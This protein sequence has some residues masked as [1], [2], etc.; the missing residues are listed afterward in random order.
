MSWIAELILYWLT[1]LSSIRTE[2]SS[3]LIW[4]MG[5]PSESHKMVRLYMLGSA[6]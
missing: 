6:M 1:V 4:M 2:M 5:F 3:K